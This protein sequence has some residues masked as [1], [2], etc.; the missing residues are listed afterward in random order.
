MCSEDIGEVFKKDLEEVSSMDEGKVEKVELSMESSQKDEVSLTKKS[1]LLK[2]GIIQ[3]NLE[4]KEKTE[5]NIM[6]KEKEVKVMNDFV[7]NCNQ[8][9]SKQCK[10]L[11]PSAP[12][13]RSN[14]SQK[15]V[16]KKLNESD[17]LSQVVRTQMNIR[18][19]RCIVTHN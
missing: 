9:G 14:Y 1:E 16:F 13:F 15:E 4:S 5:V 18:P 17:S 10:E 19:R 7:K 6:L 8:K 3:E 12:S 2:E 11:D